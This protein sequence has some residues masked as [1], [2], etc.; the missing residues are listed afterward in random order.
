MQDFEKALEKLDWMFQTIPKKYANQLWLIRAYVL[1]ALGDQ[2]RA[3]KDLKRAEK[4][5]KE[6]YRL[7]VG[8]KKSIYLTVFP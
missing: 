4:G 8:Q 5:D 2:P 6:N 3:R 1:L 7:F